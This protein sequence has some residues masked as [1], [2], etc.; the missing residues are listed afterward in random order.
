MAT[1]SDG[2]SATGGPV[3]AGSDPIAA[4]ANAP[5]HALAI[6]A[7]VYLDRAL[8][9]LLVSRF[10][11]LSSDEH[12]LLF[13]AGAGILSQFSSKI[14][15]GYAAGY[16]TRHQCSDLMLVDDI[17]KVFTQSGLA[18]TFKADSVHGTCM[19]FSLSRRKPSANRPEFDAR[20]IYYHA[21]IDLYVDM[22][23]TIRGDL[24][25]AV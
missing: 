23:M 11:E 10:Q 1:I 22:W 12:R 25:W 13:E 7:A 16:L 5:D 19:Q 24:A 3:E 6:S 9:E 4:L 17:A 21:V 2:Y 8:A 14:L 15:V 18:L 20:E